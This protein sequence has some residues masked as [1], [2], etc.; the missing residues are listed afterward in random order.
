M[1]LND[2]QPLKKINNKN[3]NLLII[4]EYTENAKYY[5]EIYRPLANEF[6]ILV[7]DWENIYCLKEDFK[8]I[9]FKDY[10]EQVI[11][12]YDLDMSKTI[13]VGSGIGGSMIALLKDY[14]QP[15]GCVYVSPIFSN[16]LVNPF[17]SNIPSYKCDL[18]SY[19]LRMK[20]EYHNLFQFFPDRANGRFLSK[21]RNYILHQEYFDTA[22]AQICLY[23][24]LKMIRKSETQFLK[25]SVIFMGTYDEIVDLNSLIKAIKFKHFKNKVP[26]LIFE[27]S[28]H[29]IELEETELFLKQLK[30]IIYEW[31]RSET[32]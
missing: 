31:I 4:P 26:I 29:H 17:T 15:F 28:S 22:I 18:N 9:N 16:T 10:V 11:K 21:Y 12:H 2:S 1:F 20:K 5:Y 14:W 7:V 27:N 8:F 13:M 25:N 30:N 19:Y 6:N 24:S 3:Y 32:L 23:D